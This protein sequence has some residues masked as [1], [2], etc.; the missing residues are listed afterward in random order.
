MCKRAVW[1]EDILN[2]KL[3]KCKSISCKGAA[4]AIATLAK[5]EQIKTP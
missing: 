2:K 4:T 3:K 5:I 1:S